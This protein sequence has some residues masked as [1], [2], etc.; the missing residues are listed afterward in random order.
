MARARTPGVSA[1]PER[2][3]HGGLVGIV[4]SKRT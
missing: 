4:C 3:A 1:P 2:I